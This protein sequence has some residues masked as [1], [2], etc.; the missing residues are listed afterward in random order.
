MNLKIH[1]KSLHSFAESIWSRRIF[2]TFLNGIAIYI[3]ITIVFGILYYLFDALDF[4]V[5]TVRLLDYIYFSA[6]TFTTIG[7]GD[8]IPKAGNNCIF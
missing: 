2:N 1:S 6:V 8:I 7:Y 4:K 3:A 5:K